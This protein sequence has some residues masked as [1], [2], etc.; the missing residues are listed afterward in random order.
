MISLG[1]PKINFQYDNPHG[2]DKLLAAV[3]TFVTEED[4][5]AE[6]QSES[7]TPGGPDNNQLAFQVCLRSC[8]VR[9]YAKIDW[10]LSGSL[11]SVS[12]KCVNVKMLFQK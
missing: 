6:R 2:F 7:S 3:E 5:D 12:H 8:F 1:A 4:L 11:V 10:Y 9:K